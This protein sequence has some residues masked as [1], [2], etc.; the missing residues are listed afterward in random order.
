M[1]TLARVLTSDPDGYSLTLT[2]S[3]SSTCS[4]EGSSN[5]PSPGLS[6]QSVLTP[7]SAPWMAPL[8]SSRC[9]S[10]QSGLLGRP[11]PAHRS[12]HGWVPAVGW[13]PILSHKALWFQ[14]NGG[15]RRGWDQRSAPPFCRQR[16]VSTSPGPC[17]GDNPVT[18][19]SAPITTP[20]AC[21]TLCAA[22]PDPALSDLPPVPDAPSPPGHPWRG[23]SLRLSLSFLGWP[24][25]YP[26]GG[27]VV[28]IQGLTW[29]KEGRWRDL[30]G[31]GQHMSYKEESSCLRAQRAWTSDGPAEPHL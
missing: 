16:C 3:P 2:R 5:H 11:G 12:V 26:P 21:P 10:L 18:W 1:G 22:R 9:H 24:S 30:G 14:A 29:C 6:A 27:A 13:V 7:A 4:H 31:G 23:L 8:Q 15:L 19:E 25:T 17:Q 28:E 20:S